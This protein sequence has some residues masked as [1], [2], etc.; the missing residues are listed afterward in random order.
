MVR[1]LVRWAW[2]GA[3]EAHFFPGNREFIFLFAGSGIRKSRREIRE[4]RV[5]DERSRWKL[6]GDR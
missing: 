4:G 6:E 2:T 1:S 3:L 5:V